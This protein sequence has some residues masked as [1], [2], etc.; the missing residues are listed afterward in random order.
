MQKQDREKQA[1]APLEVKNTG[2]GENTLLA[3]AQE[4]M[5]EGYDDVK[6]MNQ[7]VL[8]SKIM[9]IRERQIAENVNLEQQWIE[10]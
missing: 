8:A 9:T 3:K 5:D 1:N 2:F 10:E 6:H 7:M 4:Q